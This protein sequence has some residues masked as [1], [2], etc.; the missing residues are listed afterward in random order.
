MQGCAGATGQRATHHCQRALGRL[1]SPSSTHVGAAGPRVL[2]CFL[3]VREE[4]GHRKAPGAPAGAVRPSQ[5]GLQLPLV[6]AGGGTRESRSDGGV[7]GK[8][9]AVL[10]RFPRSTFGS[11]QASRFKDYR[12]QSRV[13]D[14]V[15]GC[16]GTAALQ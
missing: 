4:N 14:V 12:Y 15:Y 16:L 3:R 2:L 10:K 1:W 5:M 6:E 8:V 11:S 13:W 7:L 9:L